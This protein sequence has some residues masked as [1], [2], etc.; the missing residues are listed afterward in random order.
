[1]KVKLIQRSNPL[2]KTQAPK[3]YAHMENEGVADLRDLSKQVTKYSSLSVGDISNVLD[4]L[5]DAASLFLLMGRGVRLGNLGMLRV[6]LKS[7]GADSPAAFNTKMIHSIK[8]KFTPNVQL[9]KLLEDT[10]YEVV[11]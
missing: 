9:K 11:R 8:L 6:V 2:D 5:V 3:Y 1:M 10:S 7:E 4:N